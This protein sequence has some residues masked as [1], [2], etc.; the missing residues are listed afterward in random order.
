MN[1]GYDHT[2]F[3]T[4]IHND[5]YCTWVTAVIVAAAA[6]KKTNKSDSKPEIKFKMPQNSACK[7]S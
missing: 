2:A 7:C 1:N 4:S 6:E 5:I 3:D